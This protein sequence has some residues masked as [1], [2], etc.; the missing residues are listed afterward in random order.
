MTNSEN[1]KVIVSNFDSEEMYIINDGN[2]KNVF[3]HDCFDEYGQNIDEEA[4]GDYSLKNTYCDEILREM[5]QEGEKRFGPEFQDMNLD[6]SDMT[7]M[8]A[9]EIGLA[10]REE[11]IN[12][13]IKE[14]E[15]ENANYIECEA[16]NYWDDCNNRS[17]IIGDETVCGQFHYADDGLQAQILKEYEGVKNPYYD[18]PTES[19]PTENYVFTFS[20][21]AKDSFC[22]CAVRTTDKY[23]L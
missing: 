11:E 20:R 4:A 12:T 16:I 7:I 9:E 22:V 14:F 17:I 23:A 6:Y 1:L 18:E 15:R 3:L 10:E 19:I 21:Y 5:I 13:F 8:N 2:V